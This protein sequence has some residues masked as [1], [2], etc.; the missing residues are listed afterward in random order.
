MRHYPFI[1]RS[2]VK[3]VTV[4]AF[5]I[6]GA[7]SWAGQQIVSATTTTEPDAQSSARY[8]LFNLLDHRSA[9]GLGVYPEPFL[10]DDSDLESGEFRLD[11]L[12]AH[13]TGQQT[14]SMKAE[15]EK[16][17]GVVT[18]ELEV[19]YERTAVLGQRPTAGWDNADFGARLPV[20]QYVSPSG[21]FDT[22]FGIGMEIGV[23]IDSGFSKNAE[24]VPKVFNDTKIGDFTLQSILGYSILSGPGEDG[25]LQTFEYGFVFGYTISSEKLP[26]PGVLETIPVV[27][28]VG[29]KPLNHA[30]IHENSLTA[31]AGF[32]VN[33]APIHSI[34]P[35]L[36][37]AFVFPLNQSARQDTHWGI[38]TS[39]VFQY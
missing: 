31:D 3:A 20:F 5:T 21:G 8:G 24:F 37:L 23:P 16:S 11:W 10:V 19:P 7:S 30:D 32:R 4:L 18:L 2:V 12:H 26:I 15:I 17:F 6:A 28:L 27:E 29:E 22:T 34:Q 14:D 38:V 9:Y 1:S 36:G 13:T 39:L 35:R 25:G 33:L